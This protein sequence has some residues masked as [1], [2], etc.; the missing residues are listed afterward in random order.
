MDPQKKKLLVFGY[1]FSLIFSAIAL[2]G[3]WK[4]G[5]GLA[6]K[7]FILLGGAFLLLTL[8]KQDWLLEV[9]NRWMRVARFVGEIMTTLILAVL[10]YTV[11]SFVGIVRR[12]LRKDWLDIQID[13][14]AASYWTK[15]ELRPFNK[16][17]YTKQF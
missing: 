15:R 13:S 4:H 1:G 2:R 17:D 6:P 14:K 12:V 11:F 10:Y 3:G 5:W 9:Y 8:F 7:I 16:A